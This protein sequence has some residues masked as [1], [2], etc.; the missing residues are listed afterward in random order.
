ME[1]SK[2]N[3]TLKAKNSQ[4]KAKE[5]QISQEYEQRIL[6]L[7]SV[8]KSLNDGISD[9]NANI[10]HLQTN[11]KEHKARIAV[12]EQEVID[13]ENER[14]VLDSL[15]DDLK[16][17]LH[18]YESETLSPDLVDL[19][20]ETS[21][22]KFKLN[23][24]INL[25]ATQE[26]YIRKLKHDIEQLDAAASNS[27]GPVTLAVIEK[28]MDAKLAPLL[29]AHRLDN[30]SYASALAS[31]VPITRHVAQTNVSPLRQPFV[32]NMDTEHSTKISFAQALHASKTPVS[33]I[34]NIVLIGETRE[35]ESTYERIMNDQANTAIKFLSIV[36]HSARS[37]TVKCIDIESAIALDK[38]FKEKY[39]D[40]VEVKTPQVKSPAIKITN[41]RATFSNLQEI[42]DAIMLQ[43]PWAANA[44]F[45]IIDCYPVSNGARTY[46]NAIMNCDLESHTLLLEKGSV[47]IGMQQCRL[48]EHIDL[49]QCSNCN[50]YG[51]FW[52]NCTFA[53]YCRRCN[54]AHATRICNDRIQPPIC[55]NCVTANSSGKNYNT[56]HSSTDDRCP[57]RIARIMVLKLFHQSKN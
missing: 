57:V 39:A 51:H 10:F 1:A 54:L 21:A 9:K 32:A 12:L 30:A 26:A 19:R 36:R 56:H 40:L 46:H 18:R 52:R 5:K 25:N 15:M 17:Q 50:K 35:V 43:N 38:H 8:Q 55:N 31:Q 7:T 2:E 4:L 3:T 11:N 22:M 42:K 28:L 29:N 24:Q 14:Q 49:I 20:N 6:Q 37:I 27:D 23:E 45:E 48:F 41:I 33:N 16:A 34:R 47:I 13:K 53:P 44:N